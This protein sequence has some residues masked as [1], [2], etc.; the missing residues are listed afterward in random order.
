MLGASEGEHKSGYAYDLLSNVAT[1]NNWKCEFVYGDFNELYD[2]LLNNEIDILPCLVYTEE[3]SKQHYFSKE[4][5][6]EE[7][8]FISTLRE[9]TSDFSDIE[10]LNGKKVSS[11]ED[12]YQNVVFNEWCKENGISVQLVLTPS[13]DDS[14]EKVKDGEADFV[15]NIDNAAQSSDYRTLVAVG[16]GSSRFAIAPG[17][18]DIRQEL[19]NA[20]DTIYEINPFTITH[21]KEKYL[22]ETLSSFKLSDAEQEW[23]KNKKVIKIAGFENDIPY[24]YNEKKKNTEKTK[25][26]QKR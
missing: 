4:E 14:W 18:D 6:Y 16:S 9:K 23:I 26:T 17:R 7:Q 24:T 25:N 5:I 3:R 2:M 20:I 21:L 15:L 10:D 19:D 1:I 12:T 8:Y 13:F 11:V 22:T